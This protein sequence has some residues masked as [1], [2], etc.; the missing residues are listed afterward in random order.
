MRLLFKID[1]KKLGKKDPITYN[2]EN[3]VTCWPNE[4]DVCVGEGGG[5]SE[6]NI[7]ARGWLCEG[8]N[9]IDRCMIIDESAPSNCRENACKNVGGRVVVC[10]DETCVCKK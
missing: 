6:C 8:G 9:T 10:E 2:T 1:P 3:G 5:G 7:P 4:L